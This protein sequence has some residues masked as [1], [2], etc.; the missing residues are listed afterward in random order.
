MAHGL[1]VFRYLVGVKNQFCNTPQY[2]V[3]VD[4]KNVAEGMGKAVGLV[5]ADVIQTLDL[6]A[7]TP[8]EEM[9]KYIVFLSYSELSE[10]HI[11]Q[12]TDMVGE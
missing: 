8:D 1:R 7:E 5:R 3:T 6:P 2:E 4:A 11:I 9:R 10:I 12:R